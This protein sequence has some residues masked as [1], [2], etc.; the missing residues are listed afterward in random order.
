[1]NKVRCIAGAQHDWFP[2]SAWQEFATLITVDK[3]C[4]LMGLWRE[5]NL[6]ADQVRDESWPASE[7]KNMGVCSSDEDSF[8]SVWFHSSI[9]IYDLSYLSVA[10]PSRD[11]TEILTMSSM[12][13][14]QD[15]YQLLFYASLDIFSLTK[16]CPIPRFS[17]FLDCWTESVNRCVKGDRTCILMA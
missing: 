15:S 7:A 9:P 2:A 8:L 1:M 16:L 17:N 11:S 5:L 13:I 14:R 3:C 10:S 4:H 12:A 6:M